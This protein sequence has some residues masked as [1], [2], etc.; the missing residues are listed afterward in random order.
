L[1]GESSRQS[2]ARQAKAD[3]ENGRRGDRETRKDAASAQPSQFS[4]LP[5]F[6]SRRLRVRL[7][8]FLKSDLAAL[9]IAGGRGYTVA[10]VLDGFAALGYRE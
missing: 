5:V 10:A 1:L 3:K 6:S 2:P 8:Y 9:V 4:R 7:S